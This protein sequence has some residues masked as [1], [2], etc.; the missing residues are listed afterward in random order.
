MSVTLLIGWLIW[1][2]LVWGR[3]Q[4]PAKQLMNMRVVSLRDATHAS[5]GRMALRELV[6]KSVIGILGFFTLGLINF[7]LVWDKNKQELWDKVVGTVVVNDQ[8]DQLASPKSQFTP[9]VDAVPQ[10]QN[11]VLEP[12]TETPAPV[13][14]DAGAQ[15]ETHGV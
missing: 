6:A 7:W 1:S 15:P 5:W 11:L 2:A 10:P 13:L 12:Q 8:H 9:V 4:S 14:A 3:G